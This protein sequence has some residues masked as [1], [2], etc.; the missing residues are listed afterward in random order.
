M[1]DAREIELLDLLLQLKDLFAAQCGLE[2]NVDVLVGD[3][4]DSKKISAFAAMSG[5]QTEIQERDGCYL[6]R[7]TG[8]ICCG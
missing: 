5:C 4:R 1:I 2:V 7:I 6:V 3:F 8:S